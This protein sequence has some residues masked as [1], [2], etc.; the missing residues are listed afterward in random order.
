MEPKVGASKSELLLDQ[1]IENIID[2]KQR[3]ILEDDDNV[4]EEIV[5]IIDFIE[6]K[7][8]ASIEELI[9]NAQLLSVDML[10][11]FLTQL[12]GVIF[13]DIV[14]S[15]P[16][17]WEERVKLALKIV[18]KIEQLEVLLQ[19]SLPVGTTISN[20]IADEVTSIANENGNRTT[21]ESNGSANIFTCVG[22]E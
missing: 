21:S 12:P 4:K 19:W 6:H 22:T 2:L 17:D 16:E 11:K 1:V 3:L 10:N 18:H 8:Y 13:K 15:P 7:S 20:L 14:E 5:V 9:S